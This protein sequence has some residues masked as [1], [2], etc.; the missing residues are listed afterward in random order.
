MN[1]EMEIIQPIINDIKTKYPYEKYKEKKQQRMKEYFEKNRDV[2]IECDIC[3][4][5]YSPFTKSHHFKSQ[6]HMICI[7]IVEEQKNKI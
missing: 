6:H 2:R 7:K 4:K 5:K 1:S 3:K